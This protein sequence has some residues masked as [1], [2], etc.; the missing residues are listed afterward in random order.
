MNIEQANIYILFG[1]NRR[2]RHIGTSIC[3]SFEDLD[4]PALNKRETNPDLNGLRSVS[5]G[6]SRMKYRR[7]QREKY[8]FII[9][10]PFSPH[11]S[12]S[13]HGLLGKS[14]GD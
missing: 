12:P 5:N 6:L 11:S 7:C 9:H 4:V 2:P 1:I 3:K 14:S 8:S 13:Q 10:R